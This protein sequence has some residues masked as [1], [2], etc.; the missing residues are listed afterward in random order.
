M[1]EPFLSACARPDYLLPAYPAAAILAAY[2]LLRLAERARVP[3]PA[4][5]ASLILPLFAAV[6]LAHYELRR[7]PE[8]IV[9]HTRAVTRFA[10]SASRIG[11]MP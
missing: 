5:S 3:A 7:A 10:R 8:A 1:Y 6:Y 11:L 4:A 9:G 2:S